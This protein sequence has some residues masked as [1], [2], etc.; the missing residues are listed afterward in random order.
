MTEKESA[1]CPVSVNMVSGQGSCEMALI[2][3]TE[4]TRRLSTA[5]RVLAGHTVARVRWG[6]HV[7]GECTDI[8]NR[9]RHGHR[10]EVQLSEVVPVLN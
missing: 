4:G 1:R 3:A 7:A 8:Q 10:W 6:A 2:R 9:G 5:I